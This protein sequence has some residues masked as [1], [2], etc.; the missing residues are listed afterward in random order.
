MKND[1]PYRMI[2]ILGNSVK[3]DV[4]LVEVIEY[5]N[6]NQLHTGFCCQGDAKNRRCNGYIDFY[7]YKSL[8]AFLEIVPKLSHWTITRTGAVTDGTIRFNNKDI[9]YIESKLL[10]MV[11]PQQKG[12]QNE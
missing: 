1:H 3:I 12:K 7:R 9:P 4:D 10:N 6:D 11:R 5:L 2:N 8:K